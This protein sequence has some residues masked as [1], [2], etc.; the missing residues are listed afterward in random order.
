MNVPDH[1][2]VIGKRRAAVGRDNVP[3][4]GTLSLGWIGLDKPKESRGPFILLWIG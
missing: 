2:S 4:E 1:L 3:R